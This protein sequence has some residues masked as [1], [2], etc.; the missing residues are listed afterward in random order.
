[1]G[2]QEKA[3]NDIPAV[4][5]GEQETS[6]ELINMIMGILGQKPKLKTLKLNNLGSK[7]QGEK[8]VDVLSEQATD[9]A[10]ELR[11]LSLKK[12]PLWFNS[13]SERCVPTI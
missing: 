13:E 8:V 5:S 2:E 11:D 9:L 6:D 10:E 1:M 4:V 3:Q 7:E 12:N